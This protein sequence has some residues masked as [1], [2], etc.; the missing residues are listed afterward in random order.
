MVTDHQALTW[1]MKSENSLKG[2]R[3]RWVLRL[4]PYDFEIIYKEG[5]KHKNADALSRVRY[6]QE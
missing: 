2:R 3:A 5:R 1:L 4:Q 6:E